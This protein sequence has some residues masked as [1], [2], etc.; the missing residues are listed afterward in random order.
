MDLAKIETIV[1]YIYICHVR[2]DRAFLY[3]NMNCKAKSFCGVMRMTENDGFT[4]KRKENEVKLL[5]V[6]LSKE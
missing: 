4:L 1:G 3:E 2:A 6:Q 5:A